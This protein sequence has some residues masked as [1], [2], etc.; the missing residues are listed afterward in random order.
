M[1]V[2]P[3][4]LMTNTLEP[5]DIPAGDFPV[6]RALLSILR[7][8]PLRA[9]L[10]A[11]CVLCASRDAGGGGWCAA[12]SAAAFRASR[13]ARAS[14]RSRSSGRQ[15]LKPSALQI[16]R[17][18]PAREAK[19]FFAAKAFWFL[20]GRSLPSSLLAGLLRPPLILRQNSAPIQ[21]KSRKSKMQA[22]LS[23]RCSRTV[24]LTM[25]RLRQ[26]STVR[27]NNGHGVA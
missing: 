3:F 7:A 5:R 23:A 14:R 19:P 27:P 20:V 4:S 17:R 12:T 8:P 6:S 15:R 10:R 22:N 2:S 13:S 25:F 24:L 9:L 16:L 18:P 21:L 26:A 1:I 11:S